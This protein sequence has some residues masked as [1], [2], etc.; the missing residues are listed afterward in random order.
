MA[1]FTIT[2]VPVGNT[3]PREVAGLQAEVQ[4]AL[5]R[6]H[7]VERVTRVQHRESP[8]GAKG[9]AEVLGALLVG[10]PPGLITGVFDVLK[11]VLTRP[12]QPMTEVEINGAV[13]VKIKFDPKT[14]SLDELQAFVAKVKAAPG[15]A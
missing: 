1:E 8:E 4:D 3:T 6:V 13:T 15:P 10:I 12:A 7:G 9:V 11:G 14:V 2:L 5:E